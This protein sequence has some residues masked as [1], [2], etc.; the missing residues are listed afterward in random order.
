MRFSYNP[1]SKSFFLGASGSATFSIGSALPAQSTNLTVVV[2]N[3]ASSTVRLNRTLLGTGDPGSDP[4]QQLVVG[5]D[6]TF[7]QSS[8]MVYEIIGFNSALSAANIT[9]V[10]N[11]L[12][13]KWGLNV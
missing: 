6:G 2:V 3:G 10:S 11:Y 1:S 5:S 7:P 12:S 13:G 4:F 9:T 8:Q